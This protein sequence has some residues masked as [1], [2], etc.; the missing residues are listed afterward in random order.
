MNGKDSQ[1]GKEN[2]QLGNKVPKL[3]KHLEKLSVEIGSH[4]A[5]HR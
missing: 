3:K 4:R 2:Q 1:L 5:I